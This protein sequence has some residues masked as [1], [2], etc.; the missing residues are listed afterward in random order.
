M[1]FSVKLR[2]E[3][4]ISAIVLDSSSEND[5]LEI[6]YRLIKTS[7]I[8]TDE[9][10]KSQVNPL[11]NFTT[12]VQIIQHHKYK[13]LAHVVNCVKIEVQPADTHRGIWRLNDACFFDHGSVG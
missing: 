2:V 13:N 6:E 10:F 8:Y 9:I 12:I 11:Y 5:T 1:K 3:V 7:I 4:L